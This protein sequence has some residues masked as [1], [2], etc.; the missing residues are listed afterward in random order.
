MPEA[1]LGDRIG[2][3]I[4]SIRNRLHDHVVERRLNIRTRGSRD[5]HHPDAVPYSTFAHWAIERVLDR[6]RLAND[7]TFVD[8]GCGKGRVT[9][10]AALRSVR[11]VIGVDVDAGLCEAAG[12]NAQRMRGRRTPINIVCCPAE[13]FDYRDCTALLLFNPFNFGTLRAVLESVERSQAQHP[14]AIRLAYVNPR[15]EEVLH[16]MPRFRQYDHW[17]LQPRSRMKFA[18]SF[19]RCGDTTEV[20]SAH[21]PDQ[22]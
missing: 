14:R 18:V 2:A 10:V 13:A 22:R 6:M 3:A 7:D 20:R 8:V 1:S 12:H 19:W 5:V 16:E 15:C 4:A 17:P 11:R 21:S 9:C